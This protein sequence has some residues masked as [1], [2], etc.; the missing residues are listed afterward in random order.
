M[1]FGWL[2]AGAHG[3]DRH[4]WALDLT[5][6]CVCLQQCDDLEDEESLKHLYHIM[7]GAIML[8]HNRKCPAPPSSRQVS[9][10]M[11]AVIPSPPLLVTAKL[12]QCD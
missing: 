4:S 5:V 7:K 11:P 1:Q 10:C 8:N 2:N 9:P 6:A 3:P 12:M